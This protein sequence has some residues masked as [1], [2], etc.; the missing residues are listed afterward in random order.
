M[1]ALF[2]DADASIEGGGDTGSDEA[3]ELS[4]GFCASSSDA[5]TTGGVSADGVSQ[6]KS[7]RCSTGESVL[8][9]VLMRVSCPLRYQIS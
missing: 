7:R 2:D 1:S 6:D 8:V 3:V 4:K 5:F 9:L